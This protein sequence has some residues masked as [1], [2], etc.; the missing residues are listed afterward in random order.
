MLSKS[1]KIKK[2]CIHRAVYLNKIVLINFFFLIND[3]LAIITNLNVDGEIEFEFNFVTQGRR[4]TS[5]LSPPLWTES[6]FKW[7]LDTSNRLKLPGRYRDRIF[8][9]NFKRYW[10]SSTLTHSMAHTKKETMP[11][12][13]LSG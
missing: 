2:Y 7:I 4:V 9:R 3:K 12:A 6:C 1:D 11:N 8:L 10:L 5:Y 13:N